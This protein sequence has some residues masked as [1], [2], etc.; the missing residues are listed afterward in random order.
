MPDWSQEDWDLWNSGQWASWWGP[1]PD[2]FQTKKEESQ[3]EDPVPKGPRPPEYPPPKRAKVESTSDE[4]KDP[5]E[6]PKEETTEEGSKEPMV[7]IE[8]EPPDH[9][10]PMVEVKQEPEEASQL[11]QALAA[12]IAEHQMSHFV[13]FIKDLFCLFVC[14]FVYVLELFFHNKV[15]VVSPD[16]G[17]AGNPGPG[18]VNVQYTGSIPA[19]R[20]QQWPSAAS[21]GF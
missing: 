17:F 18:V 14:W 19:W 5:V 1:Q 11:N 3:P 8:I 15:F 21:S 6:P 7:E 2:W 9:E 13:L 12:A 16:H 4:P 10:V 20:S